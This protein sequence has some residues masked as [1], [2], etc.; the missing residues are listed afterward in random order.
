MLRWITLIAM[1][2]ALFAVFAPNQAAD[3]R[4]TMAFTWF[5]Y[6][7]ARTRD[8][9]ITADTSLIEIYYNDPTKTNP[10][11]IDLQGFAEWDFADVRFANSSGVEIETWGIISK[12]DGSVMEVLVTYTS[13][14]TI[15]IYFDNPVVD[16]KEWGLKA[17]AVAGFGIPDL[18]S[19]GFYDAISNRI[20]ITF[21]STDYA[22]S[23]TYYD[24]ATGKS[25]GY[26]NRINLPG[27]QD[28]HNDP[29]AIMTH[30]GSILFWPGAHNNAGAP[31][32]VY[33]S[34]DRE[35]FEDQRYD[36]KLSAAGGSLFDTWSALYGPDYSFGQCFV[37]ETTHTINYM[38]WYLRSQGSPS[39]SAFLNIYVANP[40]T[41]EPTG[42]TL[43]TAAISNTALIAAGGAYAAYEFATGVSVTAGTE[44]IAIWSFPGGSAANR[45]DVRIDTN[46]TYIR[47]TRTWN[48]AAYVY[49]SGYCAA[50][51]EGLGCFVAQATPIT[52]NGSYPIVKEV[53]NG[54]SYRVYVWYRT[55]ASSCGYGYR[56]SD[57]DGL[58]WS[59]E[60]N[61]IDNHIFDVNTTPYLFGI[62]I[63]EEGPTARDM[64]V[65][66]SWYDFAVSHD[67]VCYAWYDDSAATWYDAANNSIDADAG[68]GP[69]FDQGDLN[70]AA[71]E[72]VVRNV[73]Q[74]DANQLITNKLVMREEVPAIT[75]REPGVGGQINHMFTEWNGSDWTT[76]LSTIYANEYVPAAWTNLYTE[77]Y[78][79][80][81]FWD[82]D[83][84]CFYHY[85]RLATATTMEEVRYSSTTGAVWALDEQITNNS[86]YGVGML[87]YI[88][89]ATDI[90]QILYSAPDAIGGIPE[91]IH[92]WPSDFG[93]PYGESLYSTY[94][95]SP[96]LLFDDKF[97]RTYVSLDYDSPFILGLYY[98]KGARPPS[99][100][101]QYISAVGNTGERRLTFAARAAHTVS[102]LITGRTFD[103][104]TVDTLHYQFDI[105]KSGK[106]SIQLCSGLMDF[107]DLW[108]D[109]G[110]LQPDEGLYVQFTDDTHVYAYIVVGGVSTTI[111]NNVVV[112]AGDGT[113][114]IDYNWIDAVHGNGYY[115]IDWTPS[116]GATASVCTG[117]VLG[118]STD[119]NVWY[120]QTH[121][122]TE[123]I[124]IDNV[125][126]W[127]EYV[128][129]T[130]VSACV[131]LPYEVPDDFVAFPMSSTEIDLSWTKVG[132]TPYTMV[133]YSTATY[134]TI[135]TAGT[136][137][138][139][140]SNAT[141]SVDNATA[142]TT[143]YFSAWGYNA[144][145]DNQTAYATA[146]ATTPAGMDS[147][148]FSGPGG[149]PTTTPSTTIFSSVPGFFVAEWLGTV[150]MTP[151]GV[152]MR[153]VAM[154]AMS[155]IVIGIA[156]YTESIIITMLATIV[157]TALL[158]TLGLIPWYLI[159]LYAIAALG[160]GYPKEAR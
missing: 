84:N 7:W 77:S 155:I 117:N 129:N 56:Y 73:S 82:E 4:P 46:A 130:T 92:G 53:Y 85:F 148:D 72:V 11:E 154:V 28:Y 68:H 47:G 143:Y 15:Y 43:G 40:A 36:E 81:T 63:D 75:W 87:G 99:A 137:L 37:P 61:F 69:P 62:V 5:D 90:M 49:T 139:S 74:P 112:A 125:E 80:F 18:G 1:V 138:Y 121:T 14:A 26:Y 27:W 95:H 79:P 113:C 83:H 114:E 123:T 110:H 91:T 144:C 48:G 64:H 108:V 88:E 135:I 133:R 3:P 65:T 142:G 140:G 153:I 51:R 97:T 120:G 158:F 10:G 118:L 147:E 101:E 100:T 24:V 96:V 119:L 93:M 141:T 35:I 98:G 17:G 59:A 20:Y 131:V 39:G 25:A 16:P 146:V 55:L 54:S 94:T 6:S 128:V 12:T 104:S 157:G 21:M 111:A 105:Y 38:S 19:A 41:H 150:Y 115:S 89:D 124:S 66:W 30:T 57:D 22:G 78:I 122:S 107:A 116:G 159:L 33:R 34:V 8:I 31:L 29:T 134:P 32:Q 60:I 156:V 149:T 71:L 145:G 126:L 70:S 23:I 136:L 160:V 58:T 132:Y 102:H 50:F 76:N 151:A 86:P 106:T 67:N 152:V 127:P 9:T 45:L 42:V 44:Y 52:V 13:P 103:Y 109:E 2:V